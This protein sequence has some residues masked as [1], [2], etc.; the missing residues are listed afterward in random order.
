MY[1][2][3]IAYC[4]IYRERAFAFV[5][6]VRLCSE[7]HTINLSRVP[8]AGT[9]EGRVWNVG[10]SGKQVGKLSYYR[11]HSNTRTRGK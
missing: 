5:R 9:L 6:R 10:F 8:L 11:R 2:Y 7:S 3:A 1:G 4:G